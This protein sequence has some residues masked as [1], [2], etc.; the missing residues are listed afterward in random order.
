M[1]KSRQNSVCLGCLLKY[2]MRNRVLASKRLLRRSCLFPSGFSKCAAMSFVLSGFK[3]CANL[4]IVRL[5]TPRRPN[6]LSCGCGGTLITK[7]HILTAF[8]C[9]YICKIYKE[10]P[11]EDKCTARDY[12]KGEDLVLCLLLFYDYLILQGITKLYWVKTISRIQTM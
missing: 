8:H 4:R 12:S 1:R 5:C 2:K 11:N 7:K 3:D 6:R 10:C 9:V